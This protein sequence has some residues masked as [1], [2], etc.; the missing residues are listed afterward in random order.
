MGNRNR[1]AMKTLAVP[2]RYEGGVDRMGSAL[3]LRQS[4]SERIGD[5]PACKGSETFVVRSSHDGNA[6][7]VLCVCR[8]GCTGSGPV[9]EEE[10]H[11]TNDTAQIKAHPAGPTGGWPRFVNLV[12]FGSALTVARR[13][14]PPRRGS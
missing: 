1:V 14:E 7:P 10:S 12:A 2:Y 5:C 4:G 3:G 11:A 9:G 6:A 8:R 13:S